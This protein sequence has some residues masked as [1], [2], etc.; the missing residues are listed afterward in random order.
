[1]P[2]VD[3]SVWVDH[4]NHGDT[5][6]ASALQDGHVLMHPFV[7]GEIALGNLR[8]RNAVLG[9]MAG[10]PAALAANEAEVLQL[11]S[12]HKL[13]GI[14]VGYIDAHLLASAMLSNVT[15]WTRD[16]RLK[17]AAEALGLSWGMD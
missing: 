16:R 11:I 7:L 15:L 4:L 1:M 3:T 2:L 10:L 12:R 8:D 5:A 9:H 13:H 14:G 17:A 6:L